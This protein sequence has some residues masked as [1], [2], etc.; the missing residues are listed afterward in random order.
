MK[1]IIDLE[2]STLDKLQKRADGNKRSRKAEI[3]AIVEDAV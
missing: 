3:E 2:E 1:V